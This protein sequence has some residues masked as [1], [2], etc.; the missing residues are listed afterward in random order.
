MTMKNFLGFNI[1]STA[2]IAGGK[3]MAYHT[4]AIGL[5]INADVATEVNYIPEKASHLTTSMMSMGSVAI[6]DNGIYE[7]LDNN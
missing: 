4:S 7:L 2:A 3:S 6:D 5:G 1:F